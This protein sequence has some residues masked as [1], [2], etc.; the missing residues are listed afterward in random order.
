MAKVFAPVEES[1]FPDW[2]AFGAWIPEEEV[3]LQNSKGLSRKHMFQSVDDSLRRLDVDYTDVNKSIVWIMK[4]QSM[5]QVR[6]VT[7]VLLQ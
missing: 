3:D 1:Y 4:H 2:F 6:F 7:L 5:I